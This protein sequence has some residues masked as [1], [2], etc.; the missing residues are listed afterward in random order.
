MSTKEYIFVEGSFNYEVTGQGS[1]SAGPSDTGERLEIVATTN[2]ISVRDHGNGMDIKISGRRTI[3]LDYCQI[4]DIIRCVRMMDAHNK[5]EG[6]LPL[7]ISAM[8][9]R[10]GE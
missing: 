8:F 3:A 7:D 10:T 1:V 2:D 6:H 5:Q 9:A 4:A